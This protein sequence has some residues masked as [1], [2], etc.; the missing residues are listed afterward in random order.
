VDNTPP[1]CTVAVYGGHMV[2]SPWYVAFPTIQVNSSDFQP[3]SNVSSVSSR[4]WNGS[5][6]ARDWSP[7]TGPTETLTVEGKDT[8]ECQARD[9]ALWDSP[10]ANNTAW[11]DTVEP[12]T[13]SSVAGR[14]GSND[15]FTECPTVTL[16]VYELTSGLEKTMYRVDGGTWTQ[17]AGPF[18]VCG[19]KADHLVEYQSH[20]NAGNVED[21]RSITFK[22]DTNAPQ[23]SAAQPQ[24]SIGDHGWFTGPIS[25]TLTCADGTGSGCDHI[26]HAWGSDG[27]S[28]SDPGATQRT[29]SQSSDGTW[30][31]R[32]YSDDRAGLAEPERTTI[33]YGIDKTWPTISYV[34]TGR[35]GG[36][37]WYNSSVRVY[38]NAS[39][40]TS[41]VWDVTY[42]LA[43]AGDP[44]PVETIVESDR[45]V[46]DVTVD[47][48][49]QLTYRTR[50]DA[51]H[52]TDDVTVGFRIDTTPPVSDEHLDGEVVE[53]WYKLPT[54][55]TFTCDDGAG[56]SG[57]KPPVKYRVNNGS[58]LTA[59]P[60]SFANGRN[61]L[62]F[63][64][65]DM[66]LN[67]ENVQAVP[68]YVDS[69][70][71]V[72]GQPIYSHQTFVDGNGVRYVSPRTQIQ[73]RATDPL[74]GVKEVNYWIDDVKQAAL[75]NNGWFTLADKA[76]GV[77]VVKVSARD[78]AQNDE[79]EWSF[80]VTRDGT[81][82]V[83]TLVDP[84]K[85]SIT[86]EDVILSL[87]PPYV[88]AKDFASTGV[89]TPEGVHANAA[90][91]VVRRMTISATASDAPAGMSRVEFYVDGDKA[92]LD[93]ADA[94]CVVTAYPWTC[95]WDVTAYGLNNH[96]VYVKA[97][98]AFE[99]FDIRERQ[100]T[101]VPVPAPIDA[102]APVTPTMN[103][104]MKQL[105]DGMNVCVPSGWTGTQVP[106]I[107]SCISQVI[108]TMNA[109]TPDGQA[110]A[111]PAADPGH[112]QAATTS[113]TAPARDEEEP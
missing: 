53:G 91:I 3:G 39:D 98:D 22:V 11:V 55:A 23:T 35:P 32:Y 93:P 64:S 46:L 94:I 28:Q 113:T 40:E 38:L 66:A 43:R 29:V 49:Y 60:Y 47:G 62:E 99:N 16:S 74:S 41:G 110:A 24:G 101:T 97:Y 83:T 104:N 44:A 89:A 14:K 7:F 15:W 79:A 51:G 82:P 88:Q 48:T 77:H 78:V 6:L 105:I 90:A 56:A 70:K 5:A 65:Q 63:Y 13:S 103:A 107:Y 18:T 1:T 36:D 2:R 58:W 81:G 8:F 25:V 67:T 19:D 59:Q 20:D 96:M 10:I 54:T 95:P 111:S 31:L 17:Y 4:V 71:P 76:D 109:A 57:C 80:S 100:V 61:W 12:L 26:Y 45:V 37:G 42:T 112:D 75:P 102:S 33:S 30:N 106:I 21:L 27:F 87:S 84:R 34:A 85:D 68:V 108:D 73:L 72:T 92:N 50:D 69:Q 86:L 52:V 9:N